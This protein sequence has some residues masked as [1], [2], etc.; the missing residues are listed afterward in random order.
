MRYGSTG[1][2][3]WKSRHLCWRIWKEEKWPE[4]WRKGIIIPV[5]KKGRGEVRRMKEYKGVMLMSI[6]VQIVYG[7]VGKEAE[8]EGRE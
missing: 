3:I 4:E 8:G 5:I 1:G 6:P 7:G 2:R